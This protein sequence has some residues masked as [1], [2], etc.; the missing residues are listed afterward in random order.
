[1]FKSF[2]HRT[3]GITAAVTIAMSGTTAISAFAATNE[4]DAASFTKLFVGKE[5]TPYAET[6]AEGFDASGFIYYV[7][8]SFDYQVPR[9]LADQYKMNK[10]PVSDLNALQPGDVLFFGSGKKPTYAGIYVGEGNMVMASKSRDQVVTRKVSDYKKSFIGGRRVL[11]ADDLYSAQLILTAR[12]YL[13]VPY[14]FGAKY[15][16]TKT[17][18]CSSFVKTVFHEMGI[19]L[20]RVSRDQAKQ[21]K[22][23]SKKDLTVGDLVFFTTKESGSKIGHVGI[24]VGNGMMI[25]TYGEGGVKYSS[26]NSDWWSSHYVTA[27]RVIS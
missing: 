19:E 16:Q 23:V 4:M 7:F 3:I 18:D 11:N 15:G 5:Y 22:A 24:Y 14:L 26:I 25:H 12:Q 13:G 9:T 1:M 8:Q 2:A 10:P 17:M 27:R 20:P 21:G 6:P